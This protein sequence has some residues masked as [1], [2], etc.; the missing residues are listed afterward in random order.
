[1]AA[2]HS[3]T[4]EE[5]YSRV[6]ELLDDLKDISL[7]ALDA[8]YKYMLT[9][10]NDKKH[11]EFLMEKASMYTQWAS[12]GFMLDRTQKKDIWKEQEFSTEYDYELLKD[13]LTILKTIRK[14][15]DVSAMLFNLRT[16]LSRNLAGMGNPM[17]YEKS[18]VG[19]KLLIEDYIDEV[20]KQLHFICD[21]EE[22][23][24]KAKIQFIRDLQHSFGRTALLFSGGG[25]FGLAHVGP[26]KVLS[27]QNLL[28]RIITGSS[29]GSIVAAIICCQL[30]VDMIYLQDTNFV[31]K[32]FFQRPYEHGNYLIMLSRFLKH[33]VIYDVE[34]FHECMK[35]NVGDITFLEAY[36]RSRR[37]LN[38]TVSSSTTFEMPRL[39][40]FLTAP[41]VLIRSA[42]SASCALPG[43]YKSAPLMAKDAQK[44]IV[45]WNPS[46]HR[47]VDGSIEGDIPMQRV[48]ELFGVNHYLVAQGFILLI[49]LIL[50]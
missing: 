5:K 41:N 24:L 31:N 14:N 19:T 23:N 36:N 37:I 27:D 50:T 1:M 34:A 8:M 35:E 44:R 47:W 18:N 49:Q 43:V 10:R 20:T 9:N 29:S 25:S 15:A 45:P 40:N 46:G 6:T 12:A 26:I 7:T 30:D 28:P 21:C 48:C 38:I 33:G 22:L 13:R 16:S 3:S 17:L 11:Y 4:N 39:L 42:V 32:N 2:V